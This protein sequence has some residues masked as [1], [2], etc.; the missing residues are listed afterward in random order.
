MQQG[1][2]CQGS[3]PRGE[4]GVQ[5][6]A[7]RCSWTA[8]FSQY[9]VTETH[10]PTGQA[11]KPDPGVTAPDEILGTHRFKSGSGRRTEQLPVEHP[12]DN[13]RAR[14]RRQRLGRPEDRIRQNLG[15]GR[16][17]GTPGCS[18]VSAGLRAVNNA[19]EG[20]ALAE[21]ACC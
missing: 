16:V 4:V 11:G 1:G 9:D 13:H 5:S 2:A 17:R 14:V 15:P 21:F 8:T 10:A 7:K 18:G 19:A 12:A 20:T 6:E 3:A